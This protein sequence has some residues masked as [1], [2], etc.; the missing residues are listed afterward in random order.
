M[1]N[2]KLLTANEAAEFTSLNVSTLRKLAWQQRI[3]SFKVLGALRFKQSD[4][5][6]LAF[7]SR[8]EH[9]RRRRY[10]GRARR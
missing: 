4:L 5:E 8:R 2:G 7:T 10:S 1:S 3:R 9:W 6:A